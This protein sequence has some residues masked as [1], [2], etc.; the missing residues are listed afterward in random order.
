MSISLII[1]IILAGVR[2]YESV[3]QLSQTPEVTTIIG[4]ILQIAK[5]FFLDIENYETCKKK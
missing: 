2:L 5:N 1:A 4:K 3:K